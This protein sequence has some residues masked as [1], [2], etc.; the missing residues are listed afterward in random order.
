MFVALE[1]AVAKASTT[2]LFVFGRATVAETHGNISWKAEKDPM[3]C[4]NMAKYR[5]PV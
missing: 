3:A 1:T 2:A 5:G 4:R